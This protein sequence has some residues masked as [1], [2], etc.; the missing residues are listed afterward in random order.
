MIHGCSDY[1]VTTRRGHEG[2][3]R[4]NSSVGGGIEREGKEEESSCLWHSGGEAGYS[5]ASA[6]RD[7]LLVNGG[8]VS[9]DLTISRGTSN[10]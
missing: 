4:Q 5:R 2:H 6:P 7:E 9:T 10:K 8:H 1:L 3:L